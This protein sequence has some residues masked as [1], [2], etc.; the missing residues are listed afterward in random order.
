MLET[1]VLSSVYLVPNFL[2]KI[3][4]EHS[5]RMLSSVPQCIK[6][7]MLLVEKRHLLDKLPSGTSHRAFAGSSMLMNQ[8]PI[9]NQVPLNKPQIKSDCVFDQ[10][11]EI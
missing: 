5:A 2:L 10:L 6:V 8:Q 3:A 11:I 9:L 4:S 1:S 7:V